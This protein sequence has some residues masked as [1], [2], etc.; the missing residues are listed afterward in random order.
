MIDPPFVAA[1]DALVVFGQQ[2]RLAGVDITKN[3]VINVSDQLGWQQEPALSIWI[4]TTKY[5]TM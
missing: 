3:L 2:C 5:L 4:K 1:I